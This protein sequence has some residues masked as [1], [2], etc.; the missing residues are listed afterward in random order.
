[1]E[2]IIK[3]L[4]NSHTRKV[5]IFKIDCEGCEYDAMPPV[6]DAIAN[7]RLQIDQMLIELHGSRARKGAVAQFFVAADKAGY[8]ITRKECNHWGCDG[9]KCVE[10]VFVSEHFLRHATAAALCWRIE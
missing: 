1:L 10:Y 6:F 5:D 7:F 4:G 9:Y 8:C 2:S 3:E